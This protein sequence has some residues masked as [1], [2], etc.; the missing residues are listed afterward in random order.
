MTET[1]Q[2]ELSAY[3]KKHCG[4]DAKAVAD[5]AGVPRRTFY[6]WWDGRRRVVELIVAGVKFESISQSSER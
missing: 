4:M 6:D 3:C 1:K 5:L 2:A